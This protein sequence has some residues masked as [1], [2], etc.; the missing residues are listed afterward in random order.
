MIVEIPFVANGC[1]RCNQ[2]L[3]IHVVFLS[4][5]DFSMR[6]NQNSDE[7]ASKRG[8][9]QMIFGLD[10]AGHDGGELLPLRVNRLPA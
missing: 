10:L 9:I 6:Q 1:D 2:C 7:F 5:S 3:V 4:T 8:R